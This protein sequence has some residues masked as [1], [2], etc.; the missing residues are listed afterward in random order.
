MTIAQ[1]IIDS[2]LHFFDHTQNRHPFFERRDPGFEAFVGNY[3]ALPRC[4][5]PA[6]YLADVACAGGGYRAEG[7]VWHEFLS[8][9]AHK[10][11][12]WAQQL[13]N[14]SERSG[15]RIAL[16]ALVEFLDPELESKLDQYASLPNLTAVR[17][18]VI[19]DDT[20][21]LRRFSTHPNV[22]RDPAWRERL[23][24]LKRYDLK[25]GLYAFAHQLPDVI[26][27]VR[28]N[29]DIG[30]T[31]ALMGWPLDLSDAGF[32]SWKRS[33]TELAACDNVRMD[34]SALECLFGMQ[35]QVDEAARWVSTTIETIG[36][37]RCMFGSHM[38]IAGL[39]VGFAEVYRRYAEMLRAF[40]ANEADE[41]FYGVAN[42]WFMPS[43]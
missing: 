34:I 3:D 35:W 12:A 7:A 42:R 22:M 38:P 30:F 9:D 39:S 20:N 43:S 1:R 8:T 2:H 27:V 40:S 18:H 15:L 29:P 41:M 5:L 21:P 10:E 14:E 6:D 23:A 11:A 37:S 13:A 24:L 32:A 26:E 28:A 36:V 19:W 17:E 31:S 4:Y 25:C 33:L 16:C